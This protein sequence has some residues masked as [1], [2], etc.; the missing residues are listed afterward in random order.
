MESSGWL[1]KL[2]YEWDSFLFRLETAIR[3]ALSALKRGPLGKLQEHAQAWKN[4]LDFLV[5]REKERERLEKEAEKR[6]LKRLNAKKRPVREYIS[7]EEFRTELTYQ[8]W[9]YV[10]TRGP[11]GSKSNCWNLAVPNWIPNIERFTFNQSKHSWAV[12]A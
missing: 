6:R 8:H 11:L 4:Q 12:K 1:A 2:Y 9:I 10:Q 3:P 5:Q 7:Y